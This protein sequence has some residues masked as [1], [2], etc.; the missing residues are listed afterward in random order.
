MDQG[1]SY[2]TFLPHGRY[3]TDT[4]RN[5]EEALAYPE[6]YFARVFERSSLEITR[7]VPG[8]WWKNQFAQDIVV[9]RKA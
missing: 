1:M 7:V 6:E 5:P 9:A 3:W 4:P 8:E 2:R